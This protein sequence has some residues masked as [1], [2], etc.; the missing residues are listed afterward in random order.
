MNKV[1]FIG[2]HNKPGLTPLCSSTRSGK[3][4]D[5][6]IEKVNAKCYKTNFINNTSRPNKMTSLQMVNFGWNWLFRTKYK[7][8]DTV[9][10]LGKWVQEYFP[11]WLLN[12]SE[13]VKVN[14]PSYPKSKEAIADYIQ[15]TAD[16]IN[17]IVMSGD[18]FQYVPESEIKKR[19][20]KNYDYKI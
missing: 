5:Q 20:N 17:K 4:I 10:F 13:I 14:H 2:V 18:Y 1:F 15:D 3:V 16:Q 7:P 8:G 19:R 12:D 9:V 6:I 11:H